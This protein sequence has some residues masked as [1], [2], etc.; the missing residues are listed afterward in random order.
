MAGDFNLLFDSNLDAQGG[1][2]TIKKKLLAKLFEL[3]E[4]YDLCDIC[5]VENTKSKRFTFVQKHSSGFI[6]HRLDYMFISNTFQKLVTMTEKLTPISADHT[7]ALFSLSKEKGCLRG[8]IIWKFNTSLTKGQDYITEIKK[9]IRSFR[10]ANTS[11]SNRQLKWELLKYEVRKFTINYTKTA[12]K[13]K[14][15][16]A[17]KDT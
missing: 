7:P 5:R 13:S 2:P 10:T 6:Q 17:A 12:T 14:S 1:N 15:R 11:L 8:K 3:K 4:N 9:M 16:K